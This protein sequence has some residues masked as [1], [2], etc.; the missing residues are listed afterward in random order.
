MHPRCDTCS[1]R[2]RFRVQVAGQQDPEACAFMQE[3]WINHKAAAEAAYAASSAEW[4]QGRAEP[5]NALVMYFDLQNALL[6]LKILT[7][8]VYYCRNLWVYNLRI[9][10][11]L[12][13]PWMR[14]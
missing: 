14:L 7:E 1:R 4:D 2:D 3:Q 5:H 10:P 13:K 6:I 11:S 12:N 9:H 8:E